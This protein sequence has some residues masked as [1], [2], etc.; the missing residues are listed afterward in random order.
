MIWKELKLQ[1]LING[2]TAQE[3]NL[4]FDNCAGQNKN[5]MVSR[6]LFYFV[7]LKICTTARAIFLVK[8]HTKNDC[9]RMFNLLKQIYRKMDVFTPSELL[10][11]MNQ[12]PQCKAVAMEPDDFKNWDELENRMVKKAEG[13]LA[14]HIFTVK[15]R[16]SNRMMVQEYCGAE[17]ERQELVLEAYRD[18]DWTDHF[19]LETVEGPGL[20]DIKWNE[21]YAKWGRFVPEDR[22]KGLIYYI[23]KPPASL[24]KMIEEQAKAAREQRKQ[25]SRAGGKE[26][27]PPVGK[28]KVAAAAV[29]KKKPAMTKKPARKQVNAKAAA[30]AKKAKK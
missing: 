30:P 26:T 21:L 10:V 1:G 4:V 2:R 20:P 9:D 11:L 28:R 25:R 27:L 18:V 24:K 23:N 14:N 8:G 15:A 17:I 3:I 12:H 5:R 22:K 16:D 6:L 13:I 19:V 7:K 29:R